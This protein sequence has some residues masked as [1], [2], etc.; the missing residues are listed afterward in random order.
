M[1]HKT[2]RK[3][4]LRIVCNFILIV[5]I[6]AVTIET[7]AQTRKGEQP[8][9]GTSS[10][11]STTNTTTPTKTK[12][13]TSSTSKSK[14]ATS[15]PSTTQKTTTTTTTSGK[16]N[17]QRAVFKT[18]KEL[19]ITFQELTPGLAMELGV[20]PTTKGIV[21]VDVNSTSPLA[22]T[23]IVEGDIIVSINKHPVTSEKDIEIGLSKAIN[24]YSTLTINSHGKTFYEMVNMNASGN[25]TTMTTTIQTRPTG[26]Q[27]TQTT[28]TKGKSDPNSPNITVL[29]P[30]GDIKLEEEEIS[31]PDEVLREVAINI[32]EPVYPAMAKSARASGAVEVEITIDQEGNVIAAKAIS[33]HPLLK[34]SA[35][36]AARKAKFE[37]ISAQ[38]SKGNPTNIKGILVYNF[39]LN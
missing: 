9:T 21:V 24:S 33:G 5:F 38:D 30:Q 22:E 16:G 26:N 4:S 7:N 35:V 32:P 37:K 15:K 29:K 10:T 17:N 20:S 2:L 27:S 6:C 19:G 25:N 28:T 31:L 34:D 23:E 12:P 18:S 1:K 36:Q 14:T 39:V 8:K 11:G 3:F 13:K